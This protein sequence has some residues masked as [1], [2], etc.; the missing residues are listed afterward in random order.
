MS[1][2]T[3]NNTQRLAARFAGFAYF[4]VIVIG[5]FNGLGLMP[6][7][8]VEGDLAATVNNIAAN[9]MLFRTSIVLELA[10]YGLVILLAHTLYLTIKPINSVLA[11]LASFFRLAEGIVGALLV[12]LNIAA[13]VLVS[14][15]TAFE[16]EQIQTLVGLFLDVKDLGLNIVLFLMGF[17]ATIFCYLFFVSR[18][19]PRILA[20][21]GI[22]TYIVMFLG[23][24]I[25]LLFPQYTETVQMSFMPGSIFEMLFGLWLLIR[26][27][28]LQANPSGQLTTS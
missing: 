15:A 17:G 2:S 22:I 13:L 7:I 27:V 4:A 24:V 5:M 18:Y 3:T 19:V 11:L 16:P 8:Q 9:E 14:N 6:S 12:I 21:W 26:S 23:S 28:D 25:V 10:M 20:G 1:N